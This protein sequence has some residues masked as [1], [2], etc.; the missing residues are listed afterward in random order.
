MA[1]EVFLSSFG[2]RIS[3]LALFGLGSVS[4]VEWYFDL[5]SDGDCDFDLDFER[6]RS[7]AT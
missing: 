2:F 6:R 7:C 4:A 3:R 5:D 1:S